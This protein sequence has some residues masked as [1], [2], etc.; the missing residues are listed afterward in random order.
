MIHFSLLFNDFQN[1]RKTTI[2]KKKRTVTHIHLCETLVDLFLPLS[3]VPYDCG[4]RVCQMEGEAVS[5]KRGIQRRGD[6]TP[7]PTLKEFHQ[8]PY[9]EQTRSN[10]QFSLK[11]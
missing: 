10:V 5:Q 6:E 9:S 1:D 11:K 8:D 7:L 4:F 3:D 2:K